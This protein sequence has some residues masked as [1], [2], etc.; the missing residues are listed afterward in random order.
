MGADH[1]ADH[2]SFDEKPQIRTFT[3]KDI[4]SHPNEDIDLVTILFNQE[5]GG[6]KIGAMSFTEQHIPNSEFLERLPP[7][8]NVVI[9][10]YPNGLWDS[11]HNLPINRS[12]TTA[13]PP[14][15]RFENN[16]N[17]LVDVAILPGS[18]GAPVILTQAVDM[19]GTEITL[20]DRVKLLGVIS[21]WYR[22]NKDGDITLLHTDQTSN[23]VS[24]KYMIPLDV[25]RFIHSSEIINMKPAVIAKFNEYNQQKNSH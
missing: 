22:I 17:G 8:S 19:F 13:L 10:S 21:D 9:P 18:S 1:D 5:D 3:I 16:P 25:G 14:V 4:V 23:E 11:I 12:G 24:L 7:S 2:G 6:K 20:N 15:V